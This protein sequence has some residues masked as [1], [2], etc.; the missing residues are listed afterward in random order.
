MIHPLASMTPLLQPFEPVAAAVAQSSLLDLDEVALVSQGRAAIA[1]A[2]ETNAIGSGDEVLLPAF[3]CPAMSSAVRAVGATPVFF[4]IQE[5]LEIRPE[6]VTAVATARTRA[7]LIPHLFVRKQ[8]H[9]LFATLRD[10]T[11][12]LLIEDCAHSF[13][14]EPGDGPMGSSGDVAVGSIGKFFP[15]RWGGVLGSAR[16]RL[17]LRLQSSSLSLQ[18]KLLANSVEEAAD[19]GRLGVSSAAIAHLLKAVSHARSNRRSA[20]PAATPSTGHLESRADAFGDVDM[21]R[22]HQEA[23]WWASRLL[24]ARGTFAARA[25]RRHESF[26]RLRDRLRDLRH[27]RP[28]PGP[29]SPDFPPYVLPLILDEPAR[30]FQ[31]LRA[32]GVPMYRWEYSPRGICPVTDWYRESL[33]QLPCHDSMTAREIDSIAKA[34]RRALD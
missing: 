32:V 30:H 12:W 23:G 11:S 7:V 21:P 24:R 10:R 26:L 14:G 3:N 13:F 17:G 9:S 22:L 20:K 6:D 19:F 31:E 16:R 27:A 25:G 5:S 4:R 1:L 29:A 28:L 8:P 15:T 33:I 18:A 34:V 2:L